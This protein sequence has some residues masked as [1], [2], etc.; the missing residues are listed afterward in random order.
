MFSRFL[1]CF[2]PIVYTI[3]Y[4][5]DLFL[6][7]FCQRFVFFV[8]KKNS[9]FSPKEV[10]KSKISDHRGKKNKYLWCSFERWLENLGDD[11]MGVLWEFFFFA[12]FRNKN[13]WNFFRSK[14]NFFDHY[15]ENG[16]LQKFLG[17]YFQH[18]QIALYSVF[19]SMREVFV[20]K[21]VWF[22]WWTKILFF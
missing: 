13:I 17:T 6:C 4:K 20:I 15:L 10:S 19:F 12:Y 22:Y 2:V 21:F 14:I 16:E 3:V 5:I 1:F 18:N 9:N 7:F 11:G 8:E